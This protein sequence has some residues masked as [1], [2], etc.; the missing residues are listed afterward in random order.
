MSYNRNDFDGHWKR[1]ISSIFEDFLT[2]FAPDLAEIVDWS[3][4]PDDLNR[5][6][7][8]LQPDGNAKNRKADSLYRVY[9]K[10]NTAIPVL[11]HLEV[12]GWEDSEFAKRMFQYFY[13]I[14]DSYGENIYTLAI[15][16]NDNEH[17]MQDG[18]QYDFF[19]TKLTYK[20]NNF[21]VKDQKDEELI[22]SPNPFSFV[23]LAAK[24]AGQ[25]KLKDEETRYEVKKQL[26]DILSNQ[27]RL[28]SLN[29]K[30]VASLVCFMDNIIRLSDKLQTKFQ[31]EVI[32]EWEGGF[33][34]SY[35][36][37]IKEEIIDQSIKVIKLLLKQVPVEEIAIKVKLSIEEVRK[38]RD[39]FYQ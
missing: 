35:D 5:E 26:L 31:C 1:I 27:K 28:N 9:L 38:I 24:R 10:D 36:E 22:K 18:Y 7:Q 8:R 30:T 4:Q 23:V 29:D 39:K 21:K 2:F 37:E 32:E 17:F 11:V 15:F 14:F 33:M 19:G 12:Q 34:L 25:I 6:L 20:F 13:R 16:I 3:K